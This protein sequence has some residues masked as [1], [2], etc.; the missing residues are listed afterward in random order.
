[1]ALSRVENCMAKASAIP[2]VPVQLI[3][4]DEGTGTAPNGGG[5]DLLNGQ[6]RRERLRGGDGPHRV[7]FKPLRGRETPGGISS[8]NRSDEPPG[9][10]VLRRREPR[11]QTAI[12]AEQLRVLTDP[13]GPSDIG[14]EGL[15]DIQ[16]MSMP[17]SG[18]G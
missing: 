18:P 11:L 10:G 1:M 13:S 4:P 5:A 16:R 3:V 9:N 7:R 6:S 2:R 17:R 12:T 15:P 8:T 14:L